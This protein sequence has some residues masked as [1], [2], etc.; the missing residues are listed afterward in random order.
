YAVF[1]QGGQTSLAWNTSLLI[2]G[3]VAVFYT[4]AVSRA[5]RPAFGAQVGWAV[6]L[7][8]AYVG[9]QL[10]PLPLP[11]LRI[12]SPSRA[13]LIDSLMPIAQ[14]PAFASISIDPAAT[15]VYFLRTL[16][17]SLTALLI[18]ETS[19][20]WLRRRSWAPVIPLIGIAAFEGCLGIV[21]FADGGD[22]AG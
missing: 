14:P 4:L 19:W 15:S 8:P 17:Y 21:Q 5:D 6:L 3:A 2:I 20:H 11:V 7:P 1:N 13:N 18:Y 22:V 10:L 16:A 12:L 9:F